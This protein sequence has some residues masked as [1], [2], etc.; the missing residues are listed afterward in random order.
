MDGTLTPRI[1]ITEGFTV[2]ISECSG[3]YNLSYIRHRLIL[4]IG[5]KEE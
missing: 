4:N 1:I 5:N 2:P 3:V